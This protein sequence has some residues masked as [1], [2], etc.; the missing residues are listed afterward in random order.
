ME[1]AISEPD[2]KSFFERL[3]HTEHGCS[4]WLLIDPRSRDIRGAGFFN[5]FDLLRM[6]AQNYAGT[7]NLQVCRNPRPRSLLN[8]P[9]G[10]NQFNRGAVRSTPLELI[11]TL[12]TTVLL[13][14]SKGRSN[15]DQ[16]AAI[17]ASLMSRQGIN[18]YSVE[19]SGSFVAVRIRYQSSPVRRFGTLDDVRTVFARL[20]EHFRESL[21][22]E[23]KADVEL[24]PNSSPELHDSA[25]GV[26]QYLASGWE[27]GRW[28]Y[29]PADRP[30]SV[31]DQMLTDIVQGRNLRGGSGTG[32][33]TATLTVR[34]DGLLTDWIAEGPTY[35]EEA[36]IEGGGI[37][38]KGAKIKIESE[39]GKQAKGQI[40]NLESLAREAFLGRA[41]TLWRAPVATKSVSQ[42]AG[43]GVR[44][45]EVVLLESNTYRAAQDWLLSGI[46]NILK[47]D[48]VLVF[49]TSS[50][51]T[52]GAFYARGIERLGGKALEDM[53]GMGDPQVALQAQAQYRQQFKRS[54]LLFPSDPDETLASRLRQQRAFRHSD[55]AL[56]GLPALCAV[57]GFDDFAAVPGAMQAVRHMAQDAYC[58]VWLGAVGPTGISPAMV[59]LHLSLVVGEPA[60]RAWLESPETAHDADLILSRQVLPR[61]FPEVAQGRIPCAVRAVNAHEGWVM[62]AYHLYYPGTGR[63]QNIVPKREG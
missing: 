25:V 35:G 59:D 50:R 45:G 13:W 57:D 31:L 33:S 1:Q 38:P 41:R 11:E 32:Q 37:L 49:W 14:R 51:L 16:V 34:T 52:P 26:P 23:E 40:E 21:T 60:I 12:N 46:E 55:E 18:E 61:L 42:R 39:E 10:N 28:L 53:D 24:I 15:Q 47:A 48:D 56:S 8:Q 29:T 36:F 54:P 7:Y 2:L 5:D 62:H 19:T 43:G 44:P 58:A 63:F 9:G 27:M 30:D 6:A 17:A 3:G 4:E 22:S 20:E